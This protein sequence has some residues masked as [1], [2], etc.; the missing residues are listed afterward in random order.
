MQLYNDKK[1]KKKLIKS[2]SE[3]RYNHTLGVAYTAASLAMRY[4]YDIEKAYFAGLLHDCA[5]CIP[6]DKKLSMA[7]KNNLSVND[8]FKNSPDL[9][10]A[11]LGAIVAKEK[12]NIHDEDILNAIAYHT[13]GKPDMSLLEKIIYISDYIEPSRQT[14][15]NLSEIRRLAYTNLDETLYQIL[16]QTITYVKSKKTDFLPITL[17]AYEY[18]KTH[19]EGNNNE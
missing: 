7:K 16:K 15:P 9:L 1:I 13:T 8:A 18:Y 12:Y 11:E 19:R 3:S 10:H 17:E 2:L 4:D 5:K 14:I 6:N